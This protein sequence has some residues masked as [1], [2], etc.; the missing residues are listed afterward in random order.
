[1]KQC[2]KCLETKQKEE[3][4]NDKTRKDG[5]FP[6]CII[7]VKKDRVIYNQSE[8][9][10]ESLKRMHLKQKEWFKEYFKKYRKKDLTKYIARNA[11]ANAIR[12]KKIVKGKCNICG[13]VKVE[14]H[15]EDYLKPLEVIWLCKKHHT[16]KHR[17]L[18]K[19]CVVIK[20]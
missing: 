15:H 12:D 8:K 9:G 3:F 1:M 6:Y 17:E 4:N 7:C 16:M 20:K 13:E 19:F 5:K 2:K 11:V 14:G 18:R 10:K